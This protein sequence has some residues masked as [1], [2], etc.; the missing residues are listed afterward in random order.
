MFMEEKSKPS[1]EFHW[2]PAS[3]LALYKRFNA[4]FTI[5]LAII[6]AKHGDLF[7]Q[8]VGHNLIAKHI[9]KCQ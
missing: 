5:M 4:R 2:T 1:G 9:D 8:H 3:G 7:V 6:Y